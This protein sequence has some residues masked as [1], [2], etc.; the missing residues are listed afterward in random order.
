MKQVHQRFYRLVLTKAFFPAEVNSREEM[1][2]EGG[3]AT[4][5]AEAGD[6]H[7]RLCT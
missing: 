1:Y 5:Q 2:L 7:F 4:R 6:V 3:E